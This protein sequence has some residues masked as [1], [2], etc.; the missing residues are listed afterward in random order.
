MADMYLYFV[1]CYGNDADAA[2]RALATYLE[3][4]IPGRVRTHLERDRARA[5]RD[6]E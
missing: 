6:S 2:E 4:Y 3:G 5:K 1:R